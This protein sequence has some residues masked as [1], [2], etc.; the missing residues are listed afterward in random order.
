MHSEM[1]ASALICKEIEWRVKIKRGES[2]A[3]FSNKTAPVSTFY[4]ITLTGKGQKSIHINFHCNWISNGVKKELLVTS[5]LPSF[6][7]EKNPAVGV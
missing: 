5:I 7:Q 2:S 4:K 3:L 1:V 6:W